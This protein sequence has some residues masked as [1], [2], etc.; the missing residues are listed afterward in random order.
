VALGQSN[1]YTPEMVVQMTELSYA[2]ATDLASARE[3]VDY[4]LTKEVDTSV[5][6][7]RG[8]GAEESPLVVNYMTDASGE[9]IEL[10]ILL[11]EGDLVSHV[12]GGENN[13]ETLDHE[14]VVRAFSTVVDDLGSGQV[15]MTP[16]EDLVPGNAR[17]IGFVQDSATLDY[18]GAT[19]VAL[20]D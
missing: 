18:L 4:F 12:T 8:S 7:W 17:L 6:L 2:D 20:I 9:G 11:V 15:E 16:P 1:L 5:T 19:G 13:G 10:T 3:F 14:S